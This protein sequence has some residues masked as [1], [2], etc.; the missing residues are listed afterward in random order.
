MGGE[1]RRKSAGK[2][3]LIIFESTNNTDNDNYFKTFGRR[4]ADSRCSARFRVELMETDFVTVSTNQVPLLFLSC[5]IY[6]FPIDVQEV[7]EL[8]RFSVSYLT[9]MTLQTVSSVIVGLSLV[10]F[11]QGLLTN[12]FLLFFFF[13]GIRAAYT[14]LYTSIDVWNARQYVCAP[15]Y[16]RGATTE[17]DNTARTTTMIITIIKYINE[18]NNKRR[19]TLYD[20]GEQ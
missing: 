11:L 20:D 15:S 18:E 5:S 16:I 10:P 12:F 9:F 17:N 7:V 19:L 4:A 6:R 8:R 13:I 1:V 3:C 2:K 14:R